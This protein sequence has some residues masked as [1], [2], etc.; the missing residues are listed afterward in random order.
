VP[1][2]RG[3][4]GPSSGRGVNEDSRADERR[5]EATGSTMIDSAIMKG[6]SVK[7]TGVTN[8]VG[9]G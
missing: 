9:L 8:A 6:L 7:N 1:S 3:W 5:L 4:R 2:V